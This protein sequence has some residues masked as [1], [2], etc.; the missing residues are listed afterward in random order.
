MTEAKGPG[1]SSTVCT[2]SEQTMLPS[3]S[4]SYLT[5]LPVMERRS[6]WCLFLKASSQPSDALKSSMPVLFQSRIMPTQLPGN[7]QSVF[8]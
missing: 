4:S 7:V 1:R 2:S 5:G 8:P 3:L 6:M